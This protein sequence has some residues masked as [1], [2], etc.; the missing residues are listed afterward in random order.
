MTLITLRPNPAYFIKSIAEQG[1]LLETALADLIDNSITAQAKEVNIFQSQIDDRDC[2]FIADNGLG[3]SDTTLLEALRMPSQSMEAIR[4]VKDLGRF[5]LG[6][7]TASFSQSRK[8]TVISKSEEQDIYHGYCW[9]IENL[10]DDW[11]IKKLSQDEINRYVLC[12]LE[13]K[14]KANL[15][16][17]SELNTLV[18]WEQLFKDGNTKDADQYQLHDVIEHLSLVFHRFIERSSLRITVGNIDLVGF[19]PFPDEMSKMQLHRFYSDGSFTVQGHILPYA[20]LKNNTSVDLKKWLM[21]GKNLSDMEGVYLYREDRLIY[22]GGWAKLQRRQQYLKLGRLKIDINNAHDTLFQ[23]NV[24]K[25]AMLIPKSF[26]VQIREIITELA[27]KAKSVYFQRA[28]NQLK[29]PNNDFNKEILSKVI[30]KRGVFYAINQENLIYTKLIESLPSNLN[31]K[32]LAGYLEHIIKTLNNYVNIDNG[33]IEEIIVE[34]KKILSRE[35]L[36]KLKELGL[37]D[38]DIKNLMN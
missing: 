12:F 11:Q 25:S 9:D 7:K 28:P 38:F 21:N 16:S 27:E 15:S 24:A 29:V 37:S 18:I 1:Y 17:N 26:S 8:V 34:D 31:K 22:Y 30:D 14:S 19:N 23:I 36:I 33:E 6:L 32:I 3:M 10:N 13:K 2:L 20:V 35:E 4:D 5:G